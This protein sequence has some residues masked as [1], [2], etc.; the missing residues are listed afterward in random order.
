MRD[1]YV[2][3]RTFLA[4]EFGVAVAGCGFF[5][6]FDNDAFQPTDCAAEVEAH[7]ACFD[8]IGTSKTP[9]LDC[10]QSAIDNLGTV[11]Y[12]GQFSDFLCP[13]IESECA[14]C[15][16]C[17]RATED[18]LA[19]NFESSNSGSCPFYCGLPYPP[20][21]G[22]GIFTQ[23]FLALFRSFSFETDTVCNFGPQTFEILCDSTGG[24]TIEFVRAENSSASCVKADDNLL[25][26]TNPGVENFQDTG[27]IYYTCQGSELA[28]TTITLLASPQQ[29]CNVVTDGGVVGSHSRLATFC[30]GFSASSEDFLVCDNT[31][32]QDNFGEDGYP[33]IFGCFNDMELPASSGES[34][35]DFPQLSMSTN[36]NAAAYFE[37]NG[38][39]TF[40]ASSAVSPTNPPMAI[41]TMP[42]SNPTSPPSTREHRTVIGTTV[43]FTQ[44]QQLSE[45]SVVIF[46]DITSTWFNAYYNARRRHQRQLRRLQAAA[47]IQNMISQIEVTDQ[48]VSNVANIVT[49]TQTL[50][51]DATAA[52][53]D[54]TTAVDLVLAPWNDTA[55][56]T[57]NL[58]GS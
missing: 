11:S 13:A 51:Y 22:P 31:D 47:G 33:S 18:L 10:V 24:S 32:G 15:Q 2:P 45:A 5:C 49:F 4:C 34:A 1:A 29:S 57:E 28:G 38:C 40:E 42:V 14:A 19:C 8:D 52:A 46:E 44:S 7:T 54:T 41:T 43:I 30:G 56:K 6:G 55:Y 53:N 21:S 23:E 26:C 50:N 39:Y 3:R 36:S 58:L 9:C 27:F 35:L 37:S 16:G 20:P 17:E 25:R 12:C 48:T